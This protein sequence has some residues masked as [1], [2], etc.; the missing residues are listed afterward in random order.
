MNGEYEPAVVKVTIHKLVEEKRLIRDRY[1][2]RP[3]QFVM[4]KDEYIRNFPYDEYDNESD[5]KSWEKGENIFEKT[6]SVKMNGDWSVVNGEYSP[7]FYIIEIATTDKNGEAVND[8]KYK[9]LNRTDYLW[10][11]VKKT[12]AE[13]G[14]TAKVE[15]GTTADNLFVV[16]QLDNQTGI[17]DPSVHKYSFLKLH[18]EKKTFSFPVTEADRGGYGAGWMFIKHNR[19]YQLN[20]LINV[21][22]TNK[23]LGI[24]Y[25]TY[26]DMMHHLTSFI[27]MD[28]AG[29]ISGIITIK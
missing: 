8:L 28:G 12:T 24:E 14:E 22:W 21:P 15:L 10:T 7:G 16:Q 20:Q 3:D 2:E 17:Q 27:P 11:G 19:F 25:T 18:Q 4:T 26:R 29:L 1:W 5:Y 23:D 6:D 9:Q 13:P